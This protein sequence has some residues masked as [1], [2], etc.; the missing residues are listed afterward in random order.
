V[1]QAID[2]NGDHIPVGSATEAHD[3][4]ITVRDRAISQEKLRFKV[5]V[6]RTLSIIKVILPTGKSAIGQTKPTDSLNTGQ[7]ELRSFWAGLCNRISHVAQQRRVPALQRDVG[8]DIMLRRSGYIKKLAGIARVGLESSEPSLTTLA[9]QS[10]ESLR[11]EIVALEA[12][13]VKNRYLRRLGWRCLLAASLSVAAYW[14][15]SYKCPI[16]YNHLPSQ[17]LCADIP[18]LSAFRNFF[19]LSAGTAVGTWLSFSLRRVILTF[20]DL[21]S[22]EEDR[23]DPTVR[24]LFIIALSSVVGLLFWTEAVTIGIGKFHS[25]FS[26]NGTYALLIGLM[27]GIAERAMSTAVSKRAADFAGAIGGK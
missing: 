21:A 6:D 26:V 24:V 19:L 22:L 25:E 11:E 18:V 13:G 4:G 12:G 5:D 20:L 3:L 8:Y 10:L 7:D 1:V 23:L 16:D 2:I 27:L 15:I 9:T 17:R 14:S